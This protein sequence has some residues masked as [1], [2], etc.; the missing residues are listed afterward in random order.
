[1]SNCPDGMSPAETP[2]WEGKGF[3]FFCNRSCEYYPCHQVPEGEPFNCLFC[4]CPLYALGRKCGGNFHYGEGGIKDCSQCLIP[5][6]KENYGY[7]TGRFQEL[8]EAMGRLEGD[9]RAEKGP[10]GGI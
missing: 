8:V 6:K 9:G 1:M 7:I 10:D 3:S 5:H 4:Y 2:Y